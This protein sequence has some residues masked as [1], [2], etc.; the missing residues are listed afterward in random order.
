MLHYPYPPAIVSS[1]SSSSVFS[2]LLCLSGARK[3]TL[4]HLPVPTLLQPL[5]TQVLFPPLLSSSN[6]TLASYQEASKQT[7]AK[8]PLPLSAHSN[9]HRATVKGVLI[10]PLN[11][12]L[13]ISWQLRREGRREKRKGADAQTD[14]AATVLG[15]ALHLPLP[16]YS[17]DRTISPLLLRTQFRRRRRV[18]FLSPGQKKNPPIGTPLRRSETAEATGTEWKCRTLSFLLLLF[19]RNG[20]RGVSLLCRRSHDPPSPFFP[21]SKSLP[22]EKREWGGKHR[23]VWRFNIHLPPPPPSPAFYD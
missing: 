22:A 5:P 15:V 6:N 11:L 10:P 21:A 17:F 8:H 3:W 13:P 1:S 18:P 9:G 12:T 19:S 16:S 14:P 20:G 23:I 2:F 4:G 7:A